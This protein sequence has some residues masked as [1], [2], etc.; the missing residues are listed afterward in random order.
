[1]TSYLVTGSNR[2][3]GLQLCTQLQSRGDDVIAVCRQSSAALDAL[4]VEVIS[5]VD[6]SLGED[7]AKLAAA[8]HGRH[9]DVLINNAGILRRDSFDSIDFDQMEEQFRVNTLGPLRL[10]A[11]LADNLGSGGKV[12]IV[13]SR[14][15]SIADN[16]SGGNYGYRV[17]KAAVNMAGIN[18]QHD[19]APRGIALVLL[20]PGLVATE[21]TGGTGISPAESAAG[22]IQRI[23]DLEMTN[24]GRFLHAEGYE[25]PW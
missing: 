24:S 15:G 19:L 2:G 21:M 10:T 20:H 23:D 8:L 6:V 22:L 1:M 18:L 13:S 9:I 12:A 3:I 7:T 11:A 14:V 16:G 17:S 25:L 4:G 5:G